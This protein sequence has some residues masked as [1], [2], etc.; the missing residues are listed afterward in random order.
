MMPAYAFAASYPF[1]R[2]TLYWTV[3]PPTFLVLSSTSACA[4]REACA[5]SAAPARAASI[6]VACEVIADILAVPSPRGQRRSDV[7]DGSGEGRLLFGLLTFAKHD[8]EADAA[9][10]RRQHVG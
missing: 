9:G 1:G 10:P 7:D 8:D 3:T 5:T 4:G 2:T 6:R